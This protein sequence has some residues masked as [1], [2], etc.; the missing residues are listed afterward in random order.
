MKDH[1]RQVRRRVL[2]GGRILF[3]SKTSSIDCVVRDLSDGGALLLVENTLGIPSE[4]VLVMSDGRTEWCIVRSKSPNKIGVEFRTAPGQSQATSAPSPPLER[5]QGAPV[6]PLAGDLRDAA[7]RL[8][9]AGN[10]S[11]ADL[12]NR[13]ADILSFDSDSRRE[14]WAAMSMIHE[15]VGLVVPPGA[16]PSEEAINAN[17]GPTFSG[18]AQAICEALLKLR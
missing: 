12:M 15:A 11:D 9:Q 8:R 14:A 18:Y 1:R 6:L 3:N 13:A 10:D 4:F 5:K 2:K 7:V 16:L 17:Y